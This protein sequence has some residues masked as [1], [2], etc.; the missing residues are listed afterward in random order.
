[1]THFQIRH[2]PKIKASI[3]DIPK[4]KNDMEFKTKVLSKISRA[5]VEQFG[6]S[7]PSVCD[8]ENFKEFEAEIIDEILRSSKLDEGKFLNIENLLKEIKNEEFL[9]IDSEITE[10]KSKKKNPTKHERNERRAEIYKRELVALNFSKL[11]VA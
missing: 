6:T 11:S 9:T 7:K 8:L 2:F 10:R 5:I 1:M 4:Y 3:T